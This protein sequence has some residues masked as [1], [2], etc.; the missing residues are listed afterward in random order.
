[1]VSGEATDDFSQ[2]A[3]LSAQRRELQQLLARIAQRDADALKTLYERT[4]A[5]V[6]GLALR[7][8]RNV[9]DAEEV[10][11]DVYQRLWTRAGTYDPQRGSVWTLLLL[12]ARS[13]AIDRLRAARSRVRSTGSIDLEEDWT[14]PEPTPEAVHHQ[15]EFRQR[16]QDAL[17]S[18]SRVQREAVELAFFEGLT[19]EEVAVRLGQPLGTIK[20]RIRSALALLRIR[21][22]KE[23]WSE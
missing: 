3:A 14:A 13:I 21:L 17:L 12:M 2:A 9:N 7:I 16:M 6:F 5:S 19:H 20:G 8:V 4:S 10:T 18:L 22:R 15:Q 1:M 11:L 23:E